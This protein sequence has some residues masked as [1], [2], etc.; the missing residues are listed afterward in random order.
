VGFL[1]TAQPYGQVMERCQRAG[2]HPDASWVSSIY[3]LLGSGDVLDIT[4]QIQSRSDERLF[5][6]KGRQLIVVPATGNSLVFAFFFP[7]PLKAV[8]SCDVSESLTGL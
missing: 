4:K 8:K 5:D 3:F 7:A 1:A 6:K 2:N